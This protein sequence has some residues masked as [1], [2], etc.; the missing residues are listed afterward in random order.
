M[1]C[2]GSS[3][4]VCVVSNQMVFVLVVSSW[5]VFGVSESLEARTKPKNCSFHL[6]AGWSRNLGFLLRG[7]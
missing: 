2:V 6:P 3:Y 5:M 7:L 4:T 1:A